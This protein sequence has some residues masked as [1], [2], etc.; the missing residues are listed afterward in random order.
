MDEAKQQASK[1]I[2]WYEGRARPFLIEHGVSALEAID[3]DRTRLA[4][5]LAIPT[6]TYVCFLGHSGIGKSTLLNAL[7]ATDQQILPAGGIGPL[8]AQATEV[9][10][11]DKKVFRVRYHKRGAVWRAAFAVWQEAIRQ[12]AKGD[13]QVE[14]IPPGESL[15][16]D[17]IEDLRQLT[18]DSGLDGNPAEQNSAVN[19]YIGQAKKIVTGDQ[20]TE[21]PLTY[22]VDALALACGYKPKWN[23]QLNADD[24]SRVARVKSALEL[25]E[26]GQIYEHIASNGDAEFLKDLREHAAGFLSPLIQSI[27]VGWPADLLKAGIVLVDL[28]GVGIASDTYRD[29]TRQFVRDKARAIVLTVD[30]AGPTESAIDLLRVSG[31]WNRLISSADD[32]DS[33]PCSLLLAVTKVD[34]LARAERERMK[35]EGQA[36]PKLREIFAELQKELRVR[37]PQQLG[38]Q[39]PASDATTNDSL[40]VAREVARQGIL[41]SLEVHAVSAPQYRLLNVEDEEDRPFLGDVEATGI[42]GL[43]STLRRIAEADRVRRQTAVLDV[44][45][46]LRTAVQREL[47]TLESRWEED[48][49]ADEE[50]IRLHGLLSE[51]MIPKREEYKARQGGFRNYLDETVPTRIRELVLEAR[52]EAAEDIARYLGRLR[53]AHWATLRAAVRRE[54]TFHGAMYINLPD[55]LADRFQEPMAGVWGQKLLKDIRKQTTLHANDVVAIVEEICDYASQTGGA[56]VNKRQLEQQKERVQHRVDV[57]KEVGK[58]AVDELRDTVKTKI[59]ETI[60]KPIQ[61]ACKQFVRRGND[62]GPGVKNRILELFNELSRT[63]SQSAGPPAQ[64]VLS[65]NFTKVREEIRTSFQEWGDPLQETADSIVVKHEKATRRHDAKRRGEVLEA[66][67]AVKSGVPKEI[68]AE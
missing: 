36:V 19:Q 40:K 60:R 48:R 37:M 55:D 25:A 51:F 62:I 22:L 34:D 12:A 35:N 6:D 30:R 32:P 61:E 1:L 10:F 20:F 33:D 15:S 42:P 16:P 11:S 8:T 57:L 2:A 67:A 29:V 49:R 39:L 13:P 65:R 44:A 38:E 64:A 3:N 54:G 45:T 46:R 9:R 63:A 41:R 14:D 59:T 18:S 31:Y 27:D 26:K 17:E 68:R 50:K 43:S 28:P 56:S 52:T 7:A 58:E 53:N 24:E 5:L 21:R 47:E 4:G 66:I 23:S